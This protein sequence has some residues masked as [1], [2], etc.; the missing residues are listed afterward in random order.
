[1]LEKSLVSPADS[2]SYDLED[3]VAPGAKA[4]ARKLIAN[5]L[6]SGQRPKGE[7]MIRINAV[8][9]GFENE[10]IAAA[11][12]VNPVVPRAAVGRVRGACP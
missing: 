1:M 12:S 2:V 4:E 5:L 8:G 6:N 10:D 9:T 3:A 7:V 11:V